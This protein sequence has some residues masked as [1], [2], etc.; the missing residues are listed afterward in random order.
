[1][2]QKETRFNYEEYQEWRRKT[3]R[4]CKGK[5]RENIKKQLEEINQLNQQNERRKF[6]KAVNNM[7]RRFQPRMSG[8]KGKDGKI[9]GEEK[10]ILERW[11]E[12]F[13][14]LLKEAE[15]KEKENHR[16]NPT[17]TIKPDHA[18]EQV[19][20]IC[21]EPTRNEVER[22]IQRKK[23][24]RAPREDTIVAE[25]IKYGGHGIVEAVHELIK[26]IW[27]TE[28]MPQEWDTGKICPIHKKGGKLECNNY[29]GITLLNNTYKIF[30]SILNERM[31]TATEKIIGEYQC[32]FRQN[33]VQLT[34]FLYLDK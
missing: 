33:K 2:I 5:K 16:G 14:E 25:L 15:D 12:H 30:S 28:N 22:A 9:I 20:E 1:M 13:A 3:N 18:Q 24:N 26:L 19:Q 21:Q 8:F 6:Y 10:K 23:N 32:G 11:T 27:T 31:K 34:N 7:K 4:I 29:R 17:P